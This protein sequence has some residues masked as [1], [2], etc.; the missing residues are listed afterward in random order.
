MS[1]FIL[2]YGGGEYVKR[3]EA[4]ECF[5]LCVVL[6]VHWDLY[7]CMCMRLVVLNPVS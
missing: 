1:P 6:T 4:D 5:F 2:F 3:M 7:F